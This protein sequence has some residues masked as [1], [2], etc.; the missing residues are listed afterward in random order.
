MYCCRGLVGQ[1]CSPVCCD[2]GWQAVTENSRHVD[3]S[4]VKVSCGKSADEGGKVGPAHW[5]V[6]GEGP[7]EAFVKL[8]LNEYNKD[9]RNVLL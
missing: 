1:G 2:G 8:S 4:R 9:G 7:T 5:E 6:S 3:C